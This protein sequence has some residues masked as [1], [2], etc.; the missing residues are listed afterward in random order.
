MF[1]FVAVAMVFL[2]GMVIGY[3]LAVLDNARV[4]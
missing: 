3:E 2:M 4:N 1:E